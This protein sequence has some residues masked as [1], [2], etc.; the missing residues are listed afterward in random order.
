MLDPPDQDPAHF[1]YGVAIAST[2][3]PE[4]PTAIHRESFI[5]GVDALLL[6]FSTSPRQHTRNEHRQRA[7]TLDCYL[8]DF[9][10]NEGV[11]VSVDAG[12]AVAIG[13]TDPRVTDRLVRFQATEMQ[14]LAELAQQIVELLGIAG[15]CHI[16]AWARGGDG[17]AWASRWLDAGALDPGAVASME[18]EISRGQGRA[19]L[20]PE[21]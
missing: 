17:Q 11:F 4:E 21:A 10:R 9:N 16:T 20:E 15:T 5:R 7:Q 19:V 18:R 14:R 2:A 6:P 8:H 1:L 13:R 3:V 12:G